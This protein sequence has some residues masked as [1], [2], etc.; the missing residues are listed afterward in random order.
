L[1]VKRDRQKKESEEEL[2]TKTKSGREEEGLSKILASQLQVF[3]PPCGRAG[4]QIGA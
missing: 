4:T 2:S 3:L 1:L